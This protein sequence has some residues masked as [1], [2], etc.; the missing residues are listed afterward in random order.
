M[1]EATNT[2]IISLK[3]RTSGQLYRLKK[4]CALPRLS[5][6]LALEADDLDHLLGRLDLQQTKGEAA[7]REG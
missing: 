2:N 5:F 3:V 6:L 4:R 7:K 1:T